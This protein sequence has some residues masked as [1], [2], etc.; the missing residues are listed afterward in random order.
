MVIYG[1]AVARLCGE[2][3]AFEQGSLYLPRTDVN[4]QNDGRRTFTAT[5]LGLM[6]VVD[7]VSRMIVTYFPGICFVLA[8]LGKRDLLKLGFLFYYLEE[9][10]KRIHFESRSIR[11]NRSPRTRETAVGAMTFKQTLRTWSFTVLGRRMGSLYSGVARCDIVNAQAKEG[12]VVVMLSG[13][14]VPFVLRELPEDSGVSSQAEAKV[15]MDGSARRTEKPSLYKLIGPGSFQGPLYDAL[16]WEDV[17]EK[18]A[19]G[20]Y[21]VEEFTII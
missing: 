1:F 9:R 14:K 19:H 3:Q 18:Y 20:E 5:F 6:I 10:V 15:R 21:I 12:D 11:P 8:Y 2:P 4:S 13:A 7:R 16:I 17:R